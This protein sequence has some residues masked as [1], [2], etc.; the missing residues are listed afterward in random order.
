MDNKLFY[1][2]KDIEDLTR[3]ELIGA[4]KFLLNMR[5]NDRRDRKHERTMLNLF[6]KI[7]YA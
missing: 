1:R 3:E 6:R 5:E 7:R 2:G 4:L